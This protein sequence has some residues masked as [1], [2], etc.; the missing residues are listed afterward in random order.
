MRGVVTLMVLVVLSA[1]GA[2][3]ASS[4]A[5]SP[6]PPPRGTANSPSAL[7][8]AGEASLGDRSMCLVSKE[9]FT[10]SEDSPKVEHKGKTYYFCCAGCDAKFA[11]DPEKYLQ[12]GAP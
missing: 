9:E 4:G 7:K 10:V 11:A 12:A 6:P 3:A 2:P 8:R 1:C 5:A